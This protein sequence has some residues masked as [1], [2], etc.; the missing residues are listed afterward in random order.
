M[1]PSKEACASEVDVRLVQPHEEALGELSGFVEI[2]PRDV[3]QALYRPQPY[4]DDNT[5]RALP[6]ESAD[7]TI[8]LPSSLPRLLSS[9]Q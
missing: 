1:P 6:A 9:C 2:C 7:G 4:A 3:R 8:D 5:A